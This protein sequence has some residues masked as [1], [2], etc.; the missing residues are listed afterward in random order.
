[1][2]TIFTAFCDFIYLKKDNFSKSGQKFKKYSFLHHSA[3][4]HTPWR[5]TTQNLKQTTH[6]NKGDLDTC[7]KAVPMSPLP[8]AAYCTKYSSWA[9]TPPCLFPLTWCC[10]FLQGPCS[11]STPVKAVGAKPTTCRKQTKPSKSVTNVQRRLQ[12]QSEMRT[13]CP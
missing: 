12:V 13:V 11:H 3:F 9:P 10:L 7:T 2:K 1:M 6:T 5:R 4:P 8:K